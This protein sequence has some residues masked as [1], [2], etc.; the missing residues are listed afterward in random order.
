MFDVLKSLTQMQTYQPSFYIFFG[1]INVIFGIINAIKVIY[2]WNKD[3]VKIT[4]EIKR[5]TDSLPA[6]QQPSNNY[7]V[8]EV[9]NKGHK[10]V[11]INQVGIVASGKNYINI[12][13]MPWIFPLLK[14]EI[15][16]IMG[17]IEWIALPG[18]M[19]PGALGKAQI[20]FYKLEQ[21]YKEMK[22]EGEQLIEEPGYWQRINFFTL[23]KELKS[24]YNEKT[25]V[26]R[27]TPY[28]VTTTGQR[29]IGQP[30]NIQLGNLNIAVQT[31]TQREEDL[32]IRVRNFVKS[33]VWSSY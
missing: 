33:K 8:I 16:D 3:K 13:D 11:V 26:L 23:Y 14:G 9:V 22:E 31:A 32:I 2:E 17:S 12:V 29:F 27:V 30:A 20:L 25:Q 28:I 6:I 5:D 1:V 21:V 4:V 10:A 19:N 18:T 24:S 15:E 7:L